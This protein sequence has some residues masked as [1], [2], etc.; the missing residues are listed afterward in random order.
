MATGNWIAGQTGI[1][2]LLDRVSY[3]STVSHLRRII[4]PLSKKHPHFK[5]RDLHGT[6]LA[7]L[8]PNETPEG[9]SCSLV[10]NLAILAEVSIGTNDE[11]VLKILRA[12]DVK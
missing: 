9:P 3:V 12:F 6:H 7:R 8:C 2:Q 4:S 5:A 1:S 11:E 10:K